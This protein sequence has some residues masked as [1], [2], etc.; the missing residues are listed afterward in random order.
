[1]ILTMKDT[2][3]RGITLVDVNGR[4]V[5]MVQSWDTEK[6]EAKIIVG[7]RSPE[8]GIFRATVVEGNEFAL[9]TAHLPGC[10]LIFKDTKK[11]VLEE[12]LDVGS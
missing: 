10:H 9:A 2:A 12:D 5:P 3:S 8:G 11:K 4:I 7:G 6:Q 1:M